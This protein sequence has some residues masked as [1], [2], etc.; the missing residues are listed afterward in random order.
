M[1]VV[2]N[3]GIAKGDDFQKYSGRIN[4]EQKIS[5]WITFGTSTQFNYVDRSG[6]NVDF[7]DAYKMNPLAQ[8]YNEDGSLRL[9]TWESSTGCENPLAA[10]NDINSDVRKTLISNNYLVVTTP[11]EG[12]SYKLNTNLSFDSRLRQTYYGRDTYTG[13]R[14][15]GEMT[16][17]NTY[18]DR[19]LV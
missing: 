11:I 12:L 1:N 8:A 2:D 16:T 14:V 10:L 18:A 15:N 5:K 4:F 9:T 7:L 3:Q 19:W 13:N 17:Y 6:D